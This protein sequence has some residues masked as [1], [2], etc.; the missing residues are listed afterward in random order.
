MKV[1]WQ[2]HSLQHAAVRAPAGKWP[3]HRCNFKVHPSKHIVQRRPQQGDLA[4]ERQLHTDGGVHILV[5]GVVRGKKAGSNQGGLMPRTKLPPPPLTC[6]MYGCAIVALVTSILGR[7][8]SV[9]P[10]SSRPLRPGGM[11]AAPSIP[12]PLLPPLPPKHTSLHPPVQKPP[13][14]L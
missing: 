1:I 5:G 3:Q 13:D 2:R 9:Q 10:C 14:A 7:C 12:V 11:G 4:S 6:S 8:G